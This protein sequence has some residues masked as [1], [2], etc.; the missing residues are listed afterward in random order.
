MEREKA[1]APSKLLGL[2]GNPL[3]RPPSFSEKTPHGV[4][5]LLLH[6]EGDIA[7]N[8]QCLLAACWGDW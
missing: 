4:A 8:I 2:T 1:I 6:W 7:G 3:A 5:S